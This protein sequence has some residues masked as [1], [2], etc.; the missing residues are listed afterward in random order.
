[1]A[2][3]LYSCL[4][5][6]FIL[7]V[8]N[9]TTPSQSELNKIANFRRA[10]ED[11]FEVSVDGRFTINT[12]VTTSLPIAVVRGN[13]LDASTST[14]LEDIE[15]KSIERSFSQ[16]VPNG[17]R[18]TFRYMQ[19]DSN[20]SAENVTIIA[21]KFRFV[22]DTFATSIS[23]GSTIVLD[24]QLDSLTKATISGTITDSLSGQGVVADVLFFLKGDP[25][26]GPTFTTTTQ[27]NG[28]YS[29]SATI[30]NYRIEVLA[31]APYVDEVVPKNVSLSAGGTTANFALLEAEV[32]LVDD[33]GG[34]SSEADYQS[35]LDR[36]N[37]RRRTFSVADSGST[38]S[39]VLAS[40]NEKP[41]MLW[42]TAD[43]TTNA[44]TMNERL[45]IV[46]HLIGGGNAIITG[47]NMAE[48]TA[49]GD[50][51]LA[52][53]LGIQYNG[54]PTAPFLRGFAG[55]I[56][57]D[58]ISLLFTA[59]SKDMLSI[60]TGSTGQPTKTL[61]YGTSLSDTVNIA[62]V[63][64]IGPGS[65]WG[66]T[67]FGFGL[68]RLAPAFQDTFI[69]RSIRYFDQ[70]VVSVSERDAQTV[71]SE[72]TLAQSYPN[73]FNPTTQIK[74]GLPQQSHATV[75]IY[76]VV[77]Q[78]VAALFDGVQAAGF[79]EVTWN[80]TNAKGTP[81]ASGIYFYKLEAKGENGTQFT[82][83]KKML[84]LK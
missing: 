81:V 70:I 79:H 62:G 49:P 60:I 45:V 34:V 53:H 14:V 31:P 19:S 5:Q 8:Q 24:F 83:I 56:I 13:V 63:R 58:G 12:R 67:F 75:T 17:G 18:Y 3:R 27:P 7:I 74:Y 59:S 37:L 82:N 80:G 51:L 43:D 57:G 76:N 26:G 16:F 65:A 46:S 61:Y 50:T 52:K 73:P 41:V 29:V 15:V 47:Q 48:F 64:V 42:F 66:A 55:D 77:G 33:D 39:A 36:Q 44:L 25:T 72:F 38:P 21:S 11:Y 40:F 22:P 1:M 2:L 32:L 71:P 20:A 68:G 9:G 69:I 30:G 10:W 35:S 4:H 23:Y 84:L 28:S 54:A 6:A 78:K